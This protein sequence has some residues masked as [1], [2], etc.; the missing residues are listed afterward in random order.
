[1]RTPDWPHPSNPPRE[2]PLSEAGSLWAR[3]RRKLRTCVQEF[4]H[5][6][7]WIAIRNLTLSA[8]REIAVYRVAIIYAAQTGGLAADGGS[9]GPE[10]TFDF[11]PPDAVSRDVLQ[12]AWIDFERNPH[13]LYRGSCPLIVG[14]YRGE[15]CFVCVVSSDTFEIPSRQSLLLSP[16]AV[17]VACAYTISGFRGR[18]LF[19]KGLR[20]VG[21]RVERDGF[22]T[23]YLYCEIENEAARRPVHKLGFE[24]VAKS[25]VI[26]IGPVVR[27]GWK[28]LVAR[29]G[30]APKP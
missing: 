28:A 19:T 17:Y 15:T 1:M 4:R 27:L 18:G 11:E 9:L 29:P 16:R 6:G 23:V 22:D 5:F 13:G 26:R 21:S 25:W 12:A 20:A 2:Y 3:I 7:F 10:L 8:I 24:P 30:L 14:R